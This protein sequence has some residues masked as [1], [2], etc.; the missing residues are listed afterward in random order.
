[1]NKLFEKRNVIAVGKGFK[2]TNKI[3]TREM[4]VV[5]IVKEKVPLSELKDSDII[6]RTFEGLSTD[7]VES[8]EFK[9]LRLNRYRPMPGGVSGGHYKVTAGTVNGLEIDGEKILISNN[10]VIANCNDS[11]IGDRIW[12]PSN[13][14]GGNESDTIALLEKFVPIK[15][16]EP[17]NCLIANFISNACNSI[18]TLLN[19]STKLQP[20]SKPMNKVDCAYGIPINDE[21]IILDILE[22]GKPKGFN[23]TNLGHKIKKSGRT[24]GLTEGTVEIIE[25]EVQVNYGKYGTAYFENQIITTKIADPGDSGSLVLNFDDEIVGLLFAGSDTLSI[26]NDISDVLFELDLA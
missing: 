14:D 24:S 5:V 1:M 10:H 26:V 22:I 2:E 18:S 13:F 20:I 23:Y 19:R 17:S 12:Q 7:V 8:N 25:A 6:P 11:Y 15:F 4:A 21:D 16:Y 3:K 9:A